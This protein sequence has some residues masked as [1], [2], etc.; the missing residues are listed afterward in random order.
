MVWVEKCIKKKSSTVNI[1]STPSLS[2][3]ALKSATWLTNLMLWSI[4]LTGYHSPILKLQ[5]GR[6]TE[7]KVNLQCFPPS[8][9][10]D[11]RNLLLKKR[12]NRQRINEKLAVMLLWPR[13]R[14][15]R[16]PAGDSSKGP[17][18]ERKKSSKEQKSAKNLCLSRDQYR[19]STSQICTSWPRLLIWQ[20]HSLSPMELNRSNDIYKRRLMHK[21][22][23]RTDLETLLVNSQKEVHRLHLKNNNSA[24]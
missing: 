21:R 20:S 9:Q 12:W 11:R 10:K 16:N 24:M 1:K 7:D 17:R 14:N 5:Y 15:I 22:K 3:V 19:G 13:P 6:K 18:R 4:K 2:K 23:W 8:H